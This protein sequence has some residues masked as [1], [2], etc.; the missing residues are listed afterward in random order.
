[1][2]P[3][4]FKSV[5][6]TEARNCGADT[7]FYVATRNELSL[8]D[9]A[10]RDK[11][12]VRNGIMQYKP[13]FVLQILETGFT[14]GSATT[15]SFNIMLQDTAKRSVVWRANGA[16]GTADGFFAPFGGDDGGAR[17]AKKTINQMKQDG[18]FRSCP[19]TG[20]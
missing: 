2:N 11:E 15:A 3:E 19:T 6:A 13:D 9:E 1:W 14:R 8:D 17:L 20:K 10:G 7:A 4:S 16:S 18:V 5:F 12:A